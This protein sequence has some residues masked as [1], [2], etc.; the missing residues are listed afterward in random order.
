MAKRAGQVK[1]AEA[2]RPLHLRGL[3]GLARMTPNASRKVHESLRVPKARV[4]GDLI[5]V[6]ASFQARQD[7]GRGAPSGSP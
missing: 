5:H 1:V 4:L 6:H 3:D 7:E 2:R